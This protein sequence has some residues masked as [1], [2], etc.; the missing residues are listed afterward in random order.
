MKLRSDDQFWLLSS[1]ILGE[2]SLPSLA[3]A[4]SSEIL[5]VD[6][7]SSWNDDLGSS[8]TYVRRTR[9]VLWTDR[10]SVNA[11]AAANVHGRRADH[12][13]A[14]VSHGATRSTRVPRPRGNPGGLPGER[15]RGAH[16]RGGLPGSGR[17]DRSLRPLRTD[18][19]AQN[20]RSSGR[21]TM[22]AWNAPVVRRLYGVP[23]GPGQE[24]RILRC[25]AAEQHTEVSLV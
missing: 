25:F 13:G 11:V 2:G 19:V 5:Q 17:A 1:P 4:V 23:S 15:R 3:Q 22:S 14:R 12:V 7:I 16:H 18:G 9:P 8:G 6:R 24:P 21:S 10:F 20:S